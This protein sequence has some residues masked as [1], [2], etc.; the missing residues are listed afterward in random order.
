MRWF[1]YFTGAEIQLLLSIKMHKES[2]YTTD[3]LGY[4][5]QLFCAEEEQPKD[6]NSGYLTRHIIDNDTL[7]SFIDLPHLNKETH[8]DLRL[9]VKL[10]N[11]VIQDWFSV[12]DFNLLN[13]DKIQLDL[14]LGVIGLI[15]GTIIGG[16]IATVITLWLTGKI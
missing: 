9:Q 10:E 6:C 4:S 15:I 7:F 12:M 2:K 1:P 5:W 16:V 11:M 3:Q 13:K 14:F 8:Y